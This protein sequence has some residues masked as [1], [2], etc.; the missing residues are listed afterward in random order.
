VQE[1]DQ[2]SG[3]TAVDVTGATFV[4]VTTAGGKKVQGMNINLSKRKRY[5]RLVHTG[6]GGAAAG[7]AVGLILLFGG[8]NAAPVQDVTPPKNI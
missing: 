3:A 5:L 2:S 8:R 4:Q 1:D 7:Q 6:A